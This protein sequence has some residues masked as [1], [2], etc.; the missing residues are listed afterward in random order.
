MDL[1]QW[2]NVCICVFDEVHHTKKNHPYKTLADCILLYSSE[3]D[4]QI[5]GLTASLV[6]ETQQ[7]KIQRAVA[8][9]KQN[10]SIKNIICLT[11][12]ELRMQGHN[13]QTPRIDICSS[14]ILYAGC[15]TDSLIKRLRIGEGTSMEKKIYE[16]IKNMEKVVMKFETEFVSP[17]ALGKPSVEWVNYAESFCGKMILDDDDDDKF[18]LL[19]RLGQMYEALRLMENR[20]VQD[21]EEL[22]LAW[23]MTQKLLTPLADLEWDL[24][25]SKS[26]E[27]LQE[28]ISGYKFPRLSNLKEKLLQGILNSETRHIGQA[29]VFVE[30]KIT[31]Q[32]VSSYL[33]QDQE[34]LSELIKANYVTAEDKPNMTREKI[35]DCIQEFREGHLHVLVATAVVEEGLDVPNVKIVVLFDQIHTPVVLQQR[36]GRARDMNP[37]IIVMRERHGRSVAELQNAIQAQK[38][39]IE[40]ALYSDDLQP[41][42]VD[43][44][45]SR[46]REKAAFT[47]F[48]V[49]TSKTKERSIGLLHEIK[50]KTKGQ[51]LRKFDTCGSNF[52]CT[53]EYISELRK[54]GFRA[55][56]VGTSKRSAEKECAL[57]ILL[58]LRSAFLQDYH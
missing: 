56:E 13:S 7:D 18:S 48:L 3:K 46:S 55:S 32:I 9:I 16:V 49:D 6:Y 5:I 47:K 38:H 45:K 17:L 8:N 19:K 30:K 4:L 40:R 39:I 20:N 34:V 23:I 31:A 52:Q 10:L 21:G 22:S 51:L 11:E 35:R 37:E 14:P 53:L 12:N 58:L 28:I 50:D 24:L 27:E 29:I 2:K 42:S 26:S 57:K 36:F 43:L 33:Q 54:E 15:V 1:I 44:D 25:L 41:S